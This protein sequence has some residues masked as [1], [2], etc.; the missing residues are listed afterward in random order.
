MVPALTP[1]L[2]YTEKDRR[3]DAPAFSLALQGPGRL[4][5]TSPYLF[6]VTLQRVDEVNDH[7]GELHQVKLPEYTILPQLE[8]WH[9]SP[10]NIHKPGNVQQYYDVIP[11]RLIPYLQTGERY[12]LLWPGQQYGSWNWTDK[13]ENSKVVLPGGPFLSFTVKDNENTPIMPTLISGAQE[14]RPTLIAKVE[15]CPQ[16]QVA[17]QDDLVL[18]TLHV[19]YV[20]TSGSGGRPFTFNTAGL[21]VGLWVWRDRWVSLRGFVCG[22]A[23]AFVDDPDMQV[24]PGRDKGFASLRPGETWSEVLQL[25]LLT[26]MESNDGGEARAGE[27]IRCLFKGLRL[28]WWVWGSREDHLETTVT[29]PAT[30]S[31][32]VREPGEQPNAF[33]PAAA[34]VNLEII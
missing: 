22:G 16:D 17:L 27:G 25:P 11:D 12:V 4:S 9:F 2:Q 19:T 3:S 6:H 28:D 13:V 1:F 23:W 7:C 30:G 8:H 15:C 31:W 20:P 32:T 34:P 33:I 18:A 10:Y 26:D 14:C 21:T 5:R 29:I 24:S